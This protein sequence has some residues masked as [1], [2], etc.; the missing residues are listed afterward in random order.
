MTQTPMTRLALGGLLALGSAASTLHAQGKPAPKADAKAASAA[1]VTSPGGTTLITNA[2][3]LTVTKG[4]LTN[5]DILIR[6]GKIAQI[7]Q[8]L[9]APA[10]A[11]VVD[12]TGKFIMPG[13]IDPH[14]HMMSDA[15]NEGSLS[16][17]SMVRITDVLNPTAINVYR[18][19]AGGSSSESF[20]AS[21]QPGCR[22][23][24]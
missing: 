13:I 1:A 20:R 15:I 11:T 18:A 14:S 12:A 24:P 4:T 17:T 6:N 10:G 5:T 19:L 7:G 21:R 9:T 3:V 23:L 22:S 2:T 8:H 16:V